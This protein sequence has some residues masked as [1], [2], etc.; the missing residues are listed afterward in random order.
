MKIIV[1]KEQNGEIKLSKDELEKMINDAYDEGR[2]D[3]TL[4]APRPYIP[5]QPYNPLNPYKLTLTTKTGTY[6]HPE[7]GA[8]DSF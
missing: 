1:V 6:K 4:S 3:A 5:Y 8:I 2:K 7:G